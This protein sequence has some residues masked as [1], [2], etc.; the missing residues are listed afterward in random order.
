MG[1][2]T[3][4]DDDMEEAA[5]VVPTAVVPQMAPADDRV[6]HADRVAGTEH[7]AQGVCVPP[8]GDRAPG[9]D[10]HVQHL[11]EALAVAAHVRNHR[12]AWANDREATF[13]SLRKAALI[14]VRR[15]NFK[16][17]NLDE[18]QMEQGFA[19][20]LDMRRFQK[21][22]RTRVAECVGNLTSSTKWFFLFGNSTL[23][24]DAFDQLPQDAKAE[25]FKVIKKQADALGETPAAWLQPQPLPPS[26]NPFDSGYPA[27]PCWQEKGHHDYG[28][29]RGIVQP[30]SFGEERN[31]IPPA[32]AQQPWPQQTEGFTQRGLLYRKQSYEAF[33]ARSVSIRDAPVAQYGTPDSWNHLGASTQVQALPSCRS[34]S[35]PCLPLVSGKSPNSKKGWRDTLVRYIFPLVVIG[36]LVALLSFRFVVEVAGAEIV[37]AAFSAVFVVLVFFSLVRSRH[38]PQPL[39][40]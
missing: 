39:P 25:I 2:Y 17:A 36:C 7:V 20:C 10:I 27:A 21:A 4:P 30:N 37:F 6:A 40:N 28:T 1:F 16:T 34:T 33:S 3:P 32:W 9:V 13:E 38:Q 14:T 12:I 18:H 15:G 35:A 11:Q 26:S 19:F 22:Q 31:C 5:D 23:V 29:K 24:Q 8:R